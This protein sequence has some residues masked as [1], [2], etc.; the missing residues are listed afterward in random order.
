M[1]SVMLTKQDRSQRRCLFSLSEHSGRVWL[2]QNS[3]QNVLVLDGCD[4]PITIW[5][6]EVKQNHVRDQIRVFQRDSV[7]TFNLI[8]WTF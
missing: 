6:S 8:I 7:E 3:E 1:L 4:E 2:N 5:Q